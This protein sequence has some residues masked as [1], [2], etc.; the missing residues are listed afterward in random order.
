[1]ASMK[2][3]T[4]KCGCG[5]KKE[6]RTADIRRGWGKFYSK[7]CKAKKQSQSGGSDKYYKAKKKVNDRA[8]ESYYSRAIRDKDNSQSVEGDCDEDFIGGYNSDVDEGWVS[9][10]SRQF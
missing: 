8:S 4:C 9:D 6:V 2:E 1:M 7:S 3:I 10:Q 5:R